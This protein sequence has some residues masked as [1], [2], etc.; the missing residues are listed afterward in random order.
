MPPVQEGVV[1]TVDYMV[2]LTEHETDSETEE[3]T[4]SDSLEEFVAV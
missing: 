3:Q 2:E 4:A 1:L